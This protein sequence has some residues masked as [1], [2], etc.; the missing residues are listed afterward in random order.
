M[1]DFTKAYELLS[2]SYNRFRYPKDEEPSFTFF[3]NN[4]ENVIFSCPHAVKQMRNG[5]LKSADYNTGPLGLALHSL[6]QNVL[7]KTKN[8]N[9][10]ANYDLVS[11]YKDYLIQL[12]NEKKYNFVIDLHGMSETR[13]ELICLGTNF[14]KNLNNCDKITEL[15]YKI[16][17]SHN[18]QSDKIKVD[19]PFSASYEGTISAYTRAKTSINTLQIELNSLIFKNRENTIKLLQILDEFANT[20]KNNSL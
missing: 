1:K 10:D 7:I 18:F 14:G 6:G 12:I 19:H 20:I 5:Q 4:C 2:N 3:D 9:D 8:C 11:P 13:D 17:T 16:A 15:F